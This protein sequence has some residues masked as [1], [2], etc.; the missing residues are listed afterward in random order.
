MVKTFCHVCGRITPDLHENKCRMCFIEGRSFLKIPKLSVRVCKR[1]SNSL[2]KGRWQKTKGNQ[3][4]L[5]KNLSY[6]AIKESLI[7][8]MENPQVDI[9]VDE[10]LKTSNKSYSVE[11]NI[12]ATGKVLGEKCED[13]TKAIVRITLEICVDCSKKAGGYYEAVLQL[14]GNLDAELSGGDE[15]I[16]TLSQGAKTSLTRVTRLKEGIDLYFASTQVCRK[17]AKRIIEKYG[18]LLKESAHL[19]GKN[20]SGKTIYRVSMSLRLP[21]FKEGDV[22]TFDGNNYQ[23]LGFGRG[24]VLLFDLET[25]RKLSF[26]FKVT[27]RAEKLKGEV[28]EGIIL[29]VI[30]GRVQVMESKN[31]ETIEFYL[32]VPLKA[33]DDVSVFKNKRFFLMK[34][35][36]E[37]Q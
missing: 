12:S 29:E 27:A 1:C 3:D 13:E 11:C 32:N 25:R 23:V 26:P 5:L 36:E 28:V 24:K 31:Y 30:P 35:R 18:G 9:W 14:R 8:E 10:P 17:S 20:R 22:V 33:K 21:E 37:S 7:V 16:E 34:T 19:Q 2:K 15:F 4:E 6:N